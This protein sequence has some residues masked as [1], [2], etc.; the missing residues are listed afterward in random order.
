[1][2]ELHGKTVGFVGFGDIAQATA[3]LCRA[4]GMRVLAL[5]Q[6]RDAPGN[7]L[8]DEVCVTGEDPAG[9][10]LRIFRE[11]DFVLCSLPGGPATHL[12]CGEP[13]FFA[14]KDSAVF[15]SIGRGTCVDERALVQVLQSQRIAGAALDVFYSEPLAGDSPLWDCKNLLISPHN[16]DLTVTYIKQ[17]WDVFNRRLDQFRAPSFAG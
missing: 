11:S 2:N 17:S 16:A 3:R 1:M 5:R 14:M 6:T 8:A 4:L 12:F 7:E 9:A 13:E 15:I 10:K